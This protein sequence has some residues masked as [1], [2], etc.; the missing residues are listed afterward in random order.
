MYICICK[1]LKYLI[2]KVVGEP[3][4]SQPEIDFVDIVIFGYFY[5]P[6]SK[7]C[8]VSPDFLL[9]LFSNPILPAQGLQQLSLGTVNH[10]IPQLFLP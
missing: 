10:L 5:F 3:E 4:K 9:S 8:Y 2:I 7:W 6:F 1:A